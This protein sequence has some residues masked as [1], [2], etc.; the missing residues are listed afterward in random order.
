MERPDP[1]LAAP[2]MTTPTPTRPADPPR[3]PF[4]PG[5]RFTGGDLFASP[6]QTLVNPVNTEGVMG[7]GLALAFRRRYPA[8]FDAYRYHCATGTFAP[9]DLLLWRGPDRWILQ[10]PTKT[11]WRRPSTLEAI[12]AGLLRF[13]A[14]F[15]ALG[16]TS[17]AFPALGCGCGSLSWDAVRPLLV[18][19][20]ADLPIP[21][22]VHAPR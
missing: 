14:D 5:L 7:A 6:A 16:I 19:H 10:F 4:A 13:R 3:R 20:L 11:S 8:M 9:G 1:G 18:Q 12:E 15:A 22:W 17:A 21:V 2:A